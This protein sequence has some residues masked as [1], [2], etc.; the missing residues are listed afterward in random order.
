MLFL[1]VVL[2][3]LY[4]T[5]LCYS[6]QSAHPYIQTFIHIHIL[7]CTYIEMKFSID[8][9]ILCIDVVPLIV[10]DAIVLVLLLEH[11]T[12]CMYAVY[13]CM[14]AFSLNM[15]WIQRG[16][17]NDTQTHTDTLTHTIASIKS[18]YMHA[19]VLALAHTPSY[20]SYAISVCI[21]CMRCSLEYIQNHRIYLNAWLKMIS[22][23]C[24]FHWCTFTNKFLLWDANYLFF[25]VNL[26][27]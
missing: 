11:K 27:I 25:L 18:T 6:W 15:L 1:F 20:K 24:Y 9:V 4:S 22:L 26:F 2:L 3:L 8:G 7:C 21:V 14:Y 13:T 5:L 10:I 12:S 23:F 16:Y 17:I 19:L